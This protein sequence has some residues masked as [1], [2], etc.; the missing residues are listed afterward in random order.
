MEN[1]MKYLAVDRATITD[2]AAQ[3]KWT[4]R[5]LVWI[6]DDE[7]GFVAASVKEDKKEQAVVELEGGK[8]KTVNKDDIQKMNPPK[9]EK[10]EDMA[11]LTCLN[12]ASVLHNLKD[13]YFSGLIYTYSG[14]FCV[15][16]NPYKRLPIYTEKV[17]DM[18]RGK[19]R[20]EVPPHIYAITDT[21]YRSMLQDRENQSILCTGESGA[22]KTENTKKVIQYLAS[23]AGHSHTKKEQTPRKASTVSAKVGV[24]VGQVELERQLLAANPILE[25]FGNAK[26]VKNDNSSR[27]GKFIRINF[28]ASGFISGANI[29]SYLLEKSRAVRQAPN[30][31]CF[32][33]FYQVLNGLDKKSKSEMLFQD[34]GTYAYLTNGSVPVSG[35]DDA[36]DLQDSLGCMRDM[37][38]AEED[39][40]SLFRVVSSVLQ[41]G[42][43]T[44]K[45][46]RSSE[47]AIM[48]SNEV[49]QKVCHLLGIP[50]TEFS[51]AV[52]RPK[53]KVGRDYVQKAQSK[54]QAEFAIE[55]VSKSL[56]E[57]MFKWIVMRINKSMDRTKRE[58][59]SFIGILDIAGFE[60]FQ[61][62][63]FE[64]LCIN[65]TN[66]KLQ[67]LFN[68]T[69]FILEQ[70]EYRKEGI[71]W[72]FIDFGLD[73][74]PC[75]DLLEKP[76]GLMSLLDEECWFPKATDKS[77]VDKVIKEHS[78]H[79]KFKIPEFRSEAHFS[80][81]HYAGKV[82]Y[83][84]AQWLTKNMDPLNDNIIALLQNSSDPFVGQL[85]K[86]LENVVSMNATQSETPFGSKVRK[87]MFRTVSQLYKEQL[88]KLMVVLHN[89]N[90]NFVRCIIPNHEKRA[91]KISAHLVLDQL[92]CNGVLEGIRI[93]RQGFPNRMLFQ[94]FKQRYELLTPNVIPKGFMDGRKACQ[95]MLEVLELDTNSYRIGQSKIFFRAGVLAHLEEER[96]LKL[97]EIITV[98]QAYCRGNIARRHYNKRVQQLSAI[99]VI[100]RNCLSYLKLRNWQWW[101]L[102]TKV[103]PLLNV[104]RTDEALREALDLKR[105]NEEKLEKIE[106]TCQ[107]LDKNFRQVSEEKSILQEQLDRERDAFQEADDLRHRLQ[108]RK[109]ELEELLND[110]MERFDEEEEKVLA[111]TEEKKKLLKD[112]QDLE[113][114]LEEEEA[115]RQKLQLEKVTI[116]AKIKKQEEDLTLL[117]DSNSKLTKEKKS[118]DDKLQEM[119]QQLG[120]E[121]EKAKS[122]AKQKAKQ[123]A[124][125]ADLE[126]RLRNAERNCQELEKI[127][128][129]LEAELADVH[130]QLEEAKQTIQDLEATIHKKDMELNDL[131]A[132]ADEE[133]ARRS[134]LEKIKREMD[135]QI[136]ELKDDLDA[137]KS[138][139]TKAEKQ[140]RELSEELESLK[141][142][143]EE[144]IDTTTAAQD[145]RNKRESELAALKKSVE[146]ETTAHEAA[147]GQLRQKH[148]Q[149]VEELNVQLETTKKGKAQLEKAK[150][151]LE[152]SHAELKAEVEETSNRKVENERKVKVLENQLAEANAR[153]TDDEHQVA[154]LS[155]AKT[156][157]QKEL[158]AALG[159]L[160][161]IE[162]K[163]S[164]A[165]RGKALLESQMA[166]VQES[167]SDETRQKLSLSNKLKENESEINR[168][169]DQLEDEE[170][171][172]A[173]IQKNLTATQTQM[174]D[175]K[176]LAEERSAQ[177]E[178]AEQARKKVSRDVETLQARVDE[179]SAN[180]S[181]LEKTRKR[182]QDEVDDVQLNLE[183]ERAQV[184]ALEK[185]QRKFDQLLAEEKAISEKNAME[186]DNAER[187]ARQN[188]TKVISLS[189]ELEELH[190]KLAES[191][192]LRKAAQ[193]EL[194]A[195]MESKDDFGKN[196]HELEKAKRLLESQLEEKK[197]QIEELEDEVQ[198]TEDAKLRMEVNM[199]AA[200]TQFDRELASRDEQN[201]EKRK[202][203][204]KQLREL[205]S[206]LDEERKARV[207]A[208]N[209]KKKLEM[210][211]TDMEEQLEAANR[212]KE[213]GLRQ[214]KKYQQQV[215][216]IQRDLDEARQARDEISDQAKENE[217]KAKQLEADFIQM[218]EDLAAAE[219]ARK[220]LEAERDELAEELSSSSHLKGFAAEEKRK[221]EARL[222]QMEEELEDE[223]T[224]NELLSEKCRRLNL[225]TEQMQSEL[226]SERLEFQ[227][228]ESAKLTLEKQNK[229]LKAKNQELEG[230]ARLK[231]MKRI[232]A[233][234]SKISALQ[235]QLDMSAKDQAVMAK[236]N[237]KLERKCKEGMQQ[238]EE[239]RRHADQYK[240]QMEKVNARVK[241]LKRSV[242]EA[243]EENTRLATAKRRIQRELDD[244]TEANEEL[245]REVQ[246]LRNRLRGRGGGGPSGRSGYTTPPEP[247]RKT[248]RGDRSGDAGE[249]DASLDAD[250]EV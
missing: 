85:W 77:F 35:V 195:M 222:A 185:K 235:D 126:E 57:R 166:E 139:R 160:E 180:N 124:V 127:R 135:N 214:L 65:Y 167:L 155:S 184:S 218:Q 228:M 204:L 130:H 141:T 32:H 223:R 5:K 9:F 174:A 53:V 22:G 10:V 137:E 56:Y 110:Q 152:T 82:D 149:L 181:K 224:Q 50:V 115:A 156:K 112:I 227:R 206:E 186:R 145:M 129:K 120:D 221:L 168:L 116:E 7:H 170:D 243:E 104:T 11:D 14:L 27:F 29:E 31:R 52:L 172:K 142:E 55:A 182:L 231:T 202:A 211:M 37:G 70:E 220:S 13:R 189:H 154:E 89:T 28:D 84:A 207:N 43:M 150:A 108:T 163:C 138:A 4:A 45:Q 183:K 44:F 26:T 201:E 230:Q 187:D 54:S 234:E 133:A 161:E 105:A 153:L 34:I 46:E 122:L 114:G 213:D 72:K 169:Q 30:E 237:R 250:A 113:D 179:L 96:D 80:V 140:R 217:R 39:I 209:A 58:G 86:D 18:Y 88:N 42:N 92:R 132:R 111:L 51:K 49:A 69:M 131:N 165:E 33:I 60:I 17:V 106:N 144:S 118:L 91:G 151:H 81:L 23:V 240:E 193:N 100:Q 196:V 229:D 212:V 102:F 232:E 12:E 99:R 178:E 225:S 40:N 79:P 66:E 210:D 175:V 246:S 158:E 143:L 94:E 76:M 121:E 21:A 245:T 83:N 162:S 216:D 101:R 177:L 164:T 64:Q 205:E 125:I 236:T 203:L 15:V 198:I 199:Q 68:H 109:T 75:I 148:A 47:Q 200:K 244:V 226:A 90:P 146:E 147:M 78:K 123:E 2:P 233:L 157:L 41:F 24:T 107:E 16:V 188:E 48:P 215:K 93:C 8:R 197:Q 176:K 59:A 19:K 95:K 25:A 219:R 73:L 128:R 71:E 61:M 103:K 192:R 159:Q 63:S 36:A 239:E 208:T 190:E 97:T 20:H 117:E 241:T 248:T 134:E 136:E 3:A 74:Q 67:Q 87:G 62:N 191:E 98:F 1:E 238:V 173:A 242:D 171:A 194:E 6:P 119:T 38:I 249:G 247:R